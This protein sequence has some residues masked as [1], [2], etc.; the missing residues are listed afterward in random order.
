MDIF[1]KL[2][3]QVE[4]EITEK[5]IDHW[6]EAQVTTATV[7]IKVN[8]ANIYSKTKSPEIKDSLRQIL[9]N[10]LAIEQRVNDRNDQVRI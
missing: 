8:I 1:E 6:A 3:L 2:K 4:P 9:V 7:G 10:T 5:E